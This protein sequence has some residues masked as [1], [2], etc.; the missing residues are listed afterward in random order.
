MSVEIL[1]LVWLVRGG[2]EKPGQEVR[3]HHI[4]VVGNGA[5]MYVRSAYTMQV[6]VGADKA[7]LR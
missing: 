7:G 3:G 6:A 2:R 5:L 1:H 4:D